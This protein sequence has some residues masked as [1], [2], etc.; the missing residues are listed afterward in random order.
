[1]GYR[2]QRACIA[3]LAA[4]TVILVACEA[5]RRGSSA[6]GF[7]NDNLGARL[8]DLLPL[9]HEQQQSLLSSSKHGGK[10]DDGRICPTCNCSQTGSYLVSP[11]NSL[12]PHIKFLQSPQ[13]TKRDF[14]QYLSHHLFVLARNDPV[15][16][17]NASRIAL[18]D[19]FITCPDSLLSFSFAKLKLNLPTAYAFTRTSGHGRL[20][21]THK[22][23]RYLTRHADTI[24]EYYQLVE[25]EGYADGKTAKDRQFLWVVIEDDDHINPDIADWLAATQIRE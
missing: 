6:S 4:L 9:R 22:R 12:L 23:I 18:T 13:A 2:H 7:E 11:Y 20:G 15:P 17:P 25:K 24:K 14:A 3:A 19:K 5:L 1:M 10:R 21:A 16:V 8:R